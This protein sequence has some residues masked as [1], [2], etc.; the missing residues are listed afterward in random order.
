MILRLRKDRADKTVH[1]RPP[2]SQHTAKRIHMSTSLPSGPNGLTRELLQEVAHDLRS[3]ITVIQGYAET[4]L[5]KGYTLPEEQQRQYLVRLLR[6]TQIMNDLV[7]RNI[8]PDAA[9]LPSGP[10][11]QS[12]TIQRLLREICQSYELLAGRQ[13]ITLSTEIC[14]E[15]TQVWADAN[16]LRRAI[17]NLIDN[18]IKFTPEG[19]KITVY[20]CSNCAKKLLIRVSDTGMGIAPEH[21]ARIGQRHFKSSRAAGRR[22]PGQGLG[23]HIVRKILKLHGA[24]LEVTSELGQGSSFAFALPVPG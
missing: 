21:L 9:A 7:D 16:L 4:L 8:Q 2:T 17:N 22:N 15:R 12:I 20:V 24:E 13:G 23:L 14:T 1:E 5:M 6:N 18:A 3:S 11:L 10:I 19:G